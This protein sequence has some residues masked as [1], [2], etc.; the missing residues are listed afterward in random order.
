MTNQPSCYEI[1]SSNKQCIRGKTGLLGQKQVVFYSQDHKAKV[2]LELLAAIKKVPTL[3][4]MEHEVRLPSVT[5]T[6]EVK[7]KIYSREAVTYSALAYVCQEC[8]TQPIQCFTLL[9]VRETHL[10]I[11]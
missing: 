10:P 6:M 11:R 8:K 9:T 4:H 2:A 3:V 1:S 7:E 5:G